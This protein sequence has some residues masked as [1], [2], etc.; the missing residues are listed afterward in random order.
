MRMNAIMGSLLVVAMAAT[1]A[2]AECA[3]VL[4]TRMEFKDSTRPDWASGGGAYPTYSK[5]WD[6]IHRFTGIAAKGSLGDWSDWI[7]G[8]GRYRKYPIKLSTGDIR[9]TPT[10][11]GAIVQTGEIFTQWKCLPDTMDPRV[12]LKR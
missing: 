1:S 6:E 11:F 7:Y 9:A 10:E 2:S 5:C 8:L 12:Y 4:W 3:W